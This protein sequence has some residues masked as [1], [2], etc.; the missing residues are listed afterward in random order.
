MLQFFTRI[1]AINLLLGPL[2]LYTY[3]HHLPA[4]QKEGMTLDD[5][6]ANIKGVS[7]HLTTLSIFFAAIAYLIALYTLRCDE[8]RTTFLGYALFLVGAVLWAPLLRYRCV[9]ATLG[10]LTV[11]S[12][13]ALI[14]LYRAHARKNGWT[15]AAVAAGYVFCH[16]FLLDNMHWGIRHVLATSS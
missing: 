5:L 14:L 4:A 9:A 1:D 2:V 7:R 3:A 13:G 8:S 6:W 10:A 11:T 15:L 16:V 12:I